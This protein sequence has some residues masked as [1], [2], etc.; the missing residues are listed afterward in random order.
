DLD[1]EVVALRA[2]PLDRGG[3][4]VRRVRG[5]R[6]QA[7]AGVVVAA[8]ARQLPDARLHAQQFVGF[9]VRAVGQPRAARVEQV[10]RV[11]LPGEGEVL[12]DRALRDVRVDDGAVPLPV[13][14]EPGER[15]EFRLQ[16]DGDLAGHGSALQLEEG[17]DDLDAYACGTQR[18]QCDESL[19]EEDESGVVLHGRQ[20][21]PGISQTRTRSEVGTRAPADRTEVQAEARAHRDAVDSD[22]GDAG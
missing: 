9:A 1:V 17:D 10:R 16:V 6:Q 14:D 15:D 20:S 2:Q 18:G 8:G 13:P 21:N 4:G 5:G 22:A 7:G 19:E 11:P 3:G 12:A